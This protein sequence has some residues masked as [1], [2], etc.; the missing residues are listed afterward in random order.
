MENGAGAFVRVHEPSGSLEWFK[1]GRRHR[2]KGL[3][4]YIWERDWKDTYQ[5]R[6]EWWVDG[7]C[8]RSESGNVH[9]AHTQTRWYEVLCG[10]LLPFRPEAYRHPAARAEPLS[11][12]QVMPGP[13]PAPKPRGGSLPAPP[14][15]SS[16]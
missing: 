9:K 13:I 3:P 10:C 16:C 15:H 11:R 14:P 2:D 1:E 12:M 4:A 7:V 6:V 8:V 5:Y